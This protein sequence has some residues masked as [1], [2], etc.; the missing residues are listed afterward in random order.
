LAVFLV[1]ASSTYGL[2]LLLTRSRRLK[3]S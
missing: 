3:R 1:A 2:R